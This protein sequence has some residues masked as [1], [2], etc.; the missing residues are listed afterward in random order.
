MK[1][2]TGFILKATV[3]ALILAVLLTRL[4]H[5]QMGSIIAEADFFYLLLGF[6]LSFVMVG[7][8]CWKWQLILKHQGHAEPFLHLYRWYFIGYFYSN[9]LP[10]NVG[11]DVARAWYAGRA[12]GS[13]HLA[14]I[15]IFAER[16]TG[17]LVLLLLAACSPWLVPA[18]A[19]HPAVLPIRWLSILFFLT[20][21]VLFWAGAQGVR[22]SRSPIISAWMRSR[23]APVSTE[24]KRQSWRE[25]AAHHLDT[26]SRKGA[27]L[28][29]IFRNS[30]QA[31]LQITTLTILFYLL[32]WANVMLAYRAFGEW[33]NPVS[34][35][36]LLPV[37]LIVSMLPLSL[38]NLGIAEGAYVFYFS[39]VGLAPEWTLAMG[40]FLRIKILLL[41]IMGLIFHLKEPFKPGAIHGQRETA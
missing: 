22:V 36:A 33:P 13:N 41:G 12:S 2:K 14:V 18:I 15:S 20:L 30:Y 26:L 25:H 32:T 28:I 35:A 23:P 31:S 5:R 34:I 40:F 10:S 6:L 39:L 7:I 8:S 27:E 38:G 3:S 21:L 9:F 19:H 4:D 29:H 11:G 17:L 24:N 16:G 37:A 1:K